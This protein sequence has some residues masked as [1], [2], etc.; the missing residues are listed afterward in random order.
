ML[1]NKCVLK[2]LVHHF[3]E[4]VPPDPRKTRLTYDD[5]RVVELALSGAIYQGHL[6]DMGHIVAA[7]IG[8]DVALVG[9][10]AFNLCYE[11]TS[12]ALPKTSIAVAPFAFNE[13]PLAALGFEDSG[14][15]DIGMGAFEHCERMKSV[16]LPSTLSSIG[17]EAFACCTSL[18]SVYF[19]GKTAVEVKE[20]QYYPWGITDTRVISAELG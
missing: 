18:S 8:E 6:P 5:G 17:Q 14:L 16:S 9:E 7:D 15:T 11:L 2:C 1:V 10:S 12:V 4:P 13:T 19:A 3:E 20:M